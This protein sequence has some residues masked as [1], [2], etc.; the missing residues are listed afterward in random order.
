MHLSWVTTE[1]HGEDWFI[2]AHTAKE[3]ATFHEER[4]GYD[5]GDATAEKILE[6]P[7]GVNADVGCPKS[8]HPNWD[9]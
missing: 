1:D 7:E 9:S 3:A 2:M 5:I 4:E 8:C 6:I